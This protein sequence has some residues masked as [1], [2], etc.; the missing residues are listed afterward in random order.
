MILHGYV[1][2]VQGGFVCYLCRIPSII[3]TLA[4][5][6]QAAFYVPCGYQ[7]AAGHAVAA[8]AHQ[9]P[10]CGDEGH[11]LQQVREK[12][13][14]LRLGQRNDFDDLDSNGPIICGVL[15]I[16]Q[17]IGLEMKM[18]IDGGYRHIASCSEVRGHM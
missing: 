18:R 12:V 14:V 16:P 13:L 5:N 2:Q 3:V 6:Q 1:P 7:Q 10:V 11:V 9:L 4:V 15:E 8:A 17:M